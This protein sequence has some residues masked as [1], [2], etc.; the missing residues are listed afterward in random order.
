MVLLLLII[1]EH[2]VT[3]ANN[4]TGA[5]YCKITALEHIHEITMACSL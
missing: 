1:V 5:N 3:G 4:C 2:D